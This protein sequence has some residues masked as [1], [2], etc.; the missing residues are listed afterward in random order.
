M[1]F[2]LQY[3]LP[4]T[5][6]KISPHFI[7]NPKSLSDGLDLTTYSYP[8]T[9]EIKIG[10]LIGICRKERKIRCFRCSTRMAICWPV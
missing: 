6:I 7:D 4:F 10:K 1:V 3:K 5:T 2:Q 8:F 9:I